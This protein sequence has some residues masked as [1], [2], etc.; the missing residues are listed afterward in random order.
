[1]RRCAIAILCLTAADVASAQQN[2][3]DAVVYAVG[4]KDAIKPAPFRLDLSAGLPLGFSVQPRPDKFL[5][6]LTEA[7]GGELLYADG[8]RDLRQQ[9]V[10]IVQD[11]KQRYLLTYSP[12]D[13]APAGWH[14]IAVTLRHR[15]GKVTARKGYQR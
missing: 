15:A 14:T 2:S 6:A 13:V 9:F 7:T 10:N 8:T 11:F 3:S 4:L 1:M 12:R 5:A